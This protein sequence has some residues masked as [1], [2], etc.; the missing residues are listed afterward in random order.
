MTLI[1][2]YGKEVDLDSVHLTAADLEKLDALLPGVEH[3]WLKSSDE[4]LW[5][6]YRQY[7]PPKVKA[8]LIYQHGIQGH[9]GIAYRLSD[10][11]VTN[12]ALLSK[13]CMKRG[14]A[15]Y[16]PELAGHGLSE[17][18][19]FFIPNADWTTNLD[20]FDKFARHAASEHSDV[21]L[22][23]GGESYGANLVINLAGKWQKQQEKGVASDGIGTDEAPPPP[24]QFSGF[25]VNAPA[26]IG[27]LPP[28]PITFALRRI[29]APLFPTWIPFFMPHPVNPTAIWR[30]AEVRA[31]Q[32]S[33]HNKT[34]NLGGCGKPFRLGTAA[35]MVSALEHAR[36][37]TIPTLKVPYCVCHGTDDKSVHIAGT[38]YLLEHSKTDVSERSFHKDEGSYHDLLGEP[39]AE[40][41]I[42]FALDWVVERCEKGKWRLQD[43]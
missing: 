27:D 42:S 33:E 36:E 35:A 10:G 38:E 24:A 40:E 15:L 6:H 5:L 9:S 3:R 43:M 34:M 21:P 13:E 11:R 23:L 14:I 29:L 19:R 22:F 8:V 16:T 7:I 1:E 39:T 41:T 12:F 28:W 25:I 26:I 37:V 31:L 17:G 20:D 4:Q 2:L 32:T 30:D 18:T